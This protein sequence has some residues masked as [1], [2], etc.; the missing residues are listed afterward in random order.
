MRHVPGPDL[1][2]HPIHVLDTLVAVLGGAVHHVQKKR[3]AGDFLERGME[4]P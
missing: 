2:E 1:L 4:M 3:G